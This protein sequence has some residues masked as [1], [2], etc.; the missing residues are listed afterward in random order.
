MS[1]GGSRT[2]L[3][4]ASV[5]SPVSAGSRGDRKASAMY[6][7]IV[8]T[9]SGWHARI[10]DRNHKIIFWTQDYTSRQSA[11]H[12]CELVKALAASAPIRG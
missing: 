11:V 7:E 6:F 5:G 2:I 9:Q 10:K 1:S 8:H 3:C 12:A 4:A